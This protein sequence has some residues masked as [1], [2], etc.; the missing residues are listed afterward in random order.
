MESESLRARLTAA[1][2][3]RVAS[4]IIRLAMPSIRMNCGRAGHRTKLP[5]GRSGLGGSPDL[6]SGK[7]WPVWQDL[8]MAFVG[9]VNLADIA[10]HGEQG[11]FI[12]S[13][14]LSFFCA[15]DGTAAGLMLAP[16]DTS[17]WSVSLFDGGMDTL[18][19]LP[20][21]REL[22][23]P[24]NFPPCQASFSRDLTL[25]EVEA[26]EILDLRLSEPERHAYIDV[27]T[28]AD[29]G[30]LPAMSHRLLGYPYSLG[31]SP[32]ISGYL[33]AH[34]I[35]NPYT[36]A[37]MVN[38]ASQGKRDEL[39]DKWRDLQHRAEAEWGLLLQVYSNEEA[40]MDWGGGGVLHFCI[41]NEA[42]IRRDF[43]RVWVEMQSI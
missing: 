20:P 1:G 17:S 12:H 26:R 37:A 16:D 35:P 43:D 3:G 22:P 23:Q 2:L 11:H 33:R 36:M 39:Q 29:E 13:G 30:Y 41:P 40:Q 32:F 38:L 25:P 4:D 5:L 10:I 28:G 19:R 7:S 6:P 21:P 14:L 31:H 24:L 9:Q 8:P 18:V 15:I 27:Q 42:L 34:G